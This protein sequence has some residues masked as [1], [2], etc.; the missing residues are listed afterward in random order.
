MIH[1]NDHITIKTDDENTWIATEDQSGNQ[2]KI[3]SESDRE[4]RT[5]DVDEIEHREFEVSWAVLEIADQSPQE[6]ALAGI[7]KLLDG[8]AS[9]V[10]V[11]DENGELIQEFEIIIENGKARIK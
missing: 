8:E 6:A 10:D 9:L 11:C 7:Q 2:V 5:V 4:V 3:Q 1:K